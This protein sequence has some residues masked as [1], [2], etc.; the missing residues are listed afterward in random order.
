MFDR[1]RIMFIKFFTARIEVARPTKNTT[2]NPDHSL[3][4]FPRSRLLM[5]GFL[6]ARVAEVETRG[7]MAETRRFRRLGY[8]VGLVYRN[9]PWI[10][11]KMDD[12]SEDV[13]PMRYFN[14]TM[15]F[16][17]AIEYAWS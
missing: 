15:E 1:E 14:A 6:P 7:C 13:V 16:S 11:V 5:T 8:A 17:P 4:Y 2:Y 3:S 12:G 10:R 9:E